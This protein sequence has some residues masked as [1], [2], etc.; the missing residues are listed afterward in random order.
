MCDLNNL[1]IPIEVRVEFGSLRAQRQVMAARR[2]VKQQIQDQP[3][4]EQLQRA[5]R[6][7][8]QAL[9]VLRVREQSGA[10]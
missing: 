4:N 2:I 8:A 5:N 7:M 1:T 10:I 3:W 9:L 6:L